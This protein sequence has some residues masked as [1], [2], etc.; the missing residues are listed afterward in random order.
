MKTCNRYF[1]TSLNGSLI[2]AISSTGIEHYHE[3]NFEMKNVLTFLKHSIP[4]LFS[5]LQG[6]IDVVVLIG[7]NRLKIT[8]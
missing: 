1:E 8:Q 4:M 3:D 2:Y 7:D 5:V 6:H